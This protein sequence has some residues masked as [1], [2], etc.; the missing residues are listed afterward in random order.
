M[1]KNKLDDLQ[2]YRRLDTQN[3][4]ENLI[5]SP[6]QFELN[7]H[8]GQYLNLLFDPQKIKHI[9]FCGTGY[10]ILTGKIL[11]SLSPILCDVPFEIIESFRL[12]RYVD[13]NSLIIISSYS[14]NDLEPLSCYQEALTKKS[15][16]VII[17]SDGQIKNLALENH[18]PLILLE[19]RSLNPGTAS[20]S[21]FSILGASLGLLT[22][23]SPSSNLYFKST[24]MVQALEK[25]LDQ[26]RREID[27]VNNPAKS[28]AQKH[29][30]LGVVLLGSAHLLG[31]CQ[32]ISYYLQ[33]LSQTFATSSSS[34]DLFTYPID[35]KNQHQFIFLHS[36]LYP[37]QTQEYFENFKNKLLSSK[38]RLTV[39]KPDSHE[40]ATQVV[41]TLVFFIFFSYY[42]SIA[43]QVN[44]S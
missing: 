21:L 29:H 43:N 11:A 25:S 12:P 8:T 6:K 31:V 35:F 30:G 42:L 40:I 27:T 33:H 18:T 41:E 5:K 37:K 7:W 15:S 26:Y 2:N 38:Y 20:T 36:H 22:R 44:P 34:L 10:S 13:K 24:D 3:I 19:D 39:I 28:L 14:G 17:A 32:A 1:F 9:F 16:I 23:L 4:Y